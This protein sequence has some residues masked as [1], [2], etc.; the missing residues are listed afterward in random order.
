MYNAEDDATLNKRSVLLCCCPAGSYV[1]LA[2]QPMGTCRANP[3]CGGDKQPCCYYSRPEMAGVN[4]PNLGQPG[5]GYCA[6]G[7]MCKLCPETLHIVEDL[8]RCY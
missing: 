2:D 4:C 3:E 5:A 7:Y 8:M 1:P 6:L